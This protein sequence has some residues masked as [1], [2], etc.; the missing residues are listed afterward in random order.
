MFGE[1]RLP[2]ELRAFRVT[3]QSG[4]VTVIG[5]NAFQGAISRRLGRAGTPGK[6]G[7]RP[8]AEGRR[9]EKGKD[10]CVTVMRNAVMP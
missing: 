3:A 5:H 2:A 8:K 10:G 9:T 7:R 6:R 1:L 4:C